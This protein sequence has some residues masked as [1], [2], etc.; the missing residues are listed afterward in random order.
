MTL[1]RISTKRVYEPASPA[2]GQRVLVDRLWPRGVSKERAHL[3]LWMKEVAPSPELR[4]WFGH[5][6]E[7][8]PEFRR[9]Y[10]GELKANPE[11]LAALRKMAEARPL[12]L[13]FGTRD[14][15]RNEAS[16]LAEVLTEGDLSADMRPCDVEEPVHTSRATRPRSGGEGERG[17]L[18]DPG[19]H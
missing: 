18:R 15:A 11:A 1:N 3:D 2:D 12:T 14:T 17:Q 7:R 5:Q 10:T 16:V 13:L 9:R 6:P 8:W 19:R 4:R